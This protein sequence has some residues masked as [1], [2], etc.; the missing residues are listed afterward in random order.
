M[1]A[2]FLVFTI[3][4]PLYYDEGDSSSSPSQKIKSCPVSSLGE[5]LIFYFSLAG[6]DMPF[7]RCGVRPA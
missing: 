3:H 5:Q 4:S 2:F 6:A 1:K 7:D